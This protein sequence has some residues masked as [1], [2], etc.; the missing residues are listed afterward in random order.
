M[1]GTGIANNGFTYCQFGTAG[2]MHA[3]VRTST[4]AICH[5]PSAN[6]VTVTVQLSNSNAQFGSG[7]SF[8]Y[9]STCWRVTNCL[10]AS[11]TVLLR[12]RWPVSL[13]GWC[14]SLWYWPHM[15]VVSDALCCLLLN[16]AAAGG[17]TVTVIGSLLTAPIY[18]RFGAVA[19]TGNVQSA[20]VVVC[21]TPPAPAQVVRVYRTTA[22]SGRPTVSSLL[23]TVRLLR[24]CCVFALTFGAELLTVTSL[25]CTGH[26]CRRHDC[27]CDGDKF[28]SLTRCRFGSV[29]NTATRDSATQCAVLLLPLPQALCR[30]SCPTTT[31]ISRRAISCIRSLVCA[32]F[33]GRF[34]SFI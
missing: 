11:H 26:H 8:T 31:L 18:C 24:C 13:G 28:V 32:P 3:F 10:H 4:Q 29:T 30:C 34:M 27:D 22:C 9:T 17:T 16:Y 25:T 2:T 14:C 21:T 15:Y 6:L 19:V 23:T 20:S 33:A 7:Q 5:S 1:I 12:A